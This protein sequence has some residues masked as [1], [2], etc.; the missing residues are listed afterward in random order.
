[1]ATLLRN[2]YI[3]L[4]LCGVTWFSPAAA[5]TLSARWVKT[6]A[7]IGQPSALQSILAAQNAVVLPHRTPQPMSF[8]RPAPTAQ[9]HIEDRADEG[10]TSGRPDVFGSVALSVSRTPLDARWRRAGASGIG[11]A[12]ATFASGLTGK[13]R[14][15]QLE[16]V[17]RYV[18]DRVSFLDDQVQ[19]GRADVWSSASETLRRRKGDC[20]D[21]AIAKMKM[22]KHAGFTDRDLYVVIVRD[23]VRR[24]DH[25]VLVARADGRMYVLDNGTDK[26]LDSASV[27]DYRPLMTF[28]SRGAWTHGYRR[29]PVAVQMAQN[30]VVAGMPTLGN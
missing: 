22:L 17:N 9:Y 25:A 10:A 24:N 1:M 27:A 26:L 16:A 15:A 29:Q 20:E 8:A 11:G 19:F 5:E 28:A 14:I 30:N 4:A 13:D 12:A 2:L 18:N 23:L 6:E 7:I 21:Y 3:C